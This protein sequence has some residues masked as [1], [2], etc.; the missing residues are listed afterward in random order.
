MIKFILAI[1][2]ACLG[3]T[4][5]LPFAGMVSAPTATPC[6]PAST[7]ERSMPALAQTLEARLNDAGLTGMQVYATGFQNCPQIAEADYP[8]WFHIT[9]PVDDVTDTATLGALTAQVLP[10]LA[11][12]P[13]VVLYLIFEDSTDRV[14]VPFQIQTG[15]DLL[16]QNVTG[17]TLLEQLQNQQ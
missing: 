8:V 14:S 16:D 13:S 12:W 6:P 4:I 1:L 9:I 2:F 15:L 10:P 5:V 17:Q 3:L 11:D 7:P